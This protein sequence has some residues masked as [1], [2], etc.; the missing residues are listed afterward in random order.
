MKKVS[1]ILIGLILFLVIAGCT[2]VAQ[3]V[4]PPVEYKKAI[5]LHVKK[6]AYLNW[7]YGKEYAGK[8]MMFGPADPVGALLVTA[9]DNEAQR[10]NPD[11]YKFTYGKAQQAVF[12]TS[13]RDVLVEQN[14]FKNVS[15]TTA[16]RKLNPNDVIITV[17]FRETRVAN[18]N[19][20]FDM[21]LNVDLFIKTINEPV[22]KRT[23]V[24]KSSPSGLFGRGFKD[25][26]T[27]V[28]QQLLD[29]IISGL[30]QWHYKIN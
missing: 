25:Q 2:P 22:F 3:Q 24:I 8:S 15:L 21:T 28:S 5:D 18:Q 29:R 26:Q 10:R 9:I 30:S 14:V 16:S 27:D 13:L 11:H 12:M 23:Y 20:F 1:L 4:M 19:E 17:K 7:E 6:N